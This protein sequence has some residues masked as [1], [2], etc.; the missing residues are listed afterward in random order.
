MR[1]LEHPSRAPA[2]RT[3]AVTAVALTMAFVGVWVAQ[4][5]PAAAHHTSVTTTVYTWEPGEGDPYNGINVFLS[6]P[7]HSNSGSKGE[8]ANGYEENINGRYHNTQGGGGGY[9]WEEPSTSSGRSLIGRGYRVQIGPNPRDDGIGWG[10]GQNGWLSREFGASVHITTHSN[11]TTGCPGSANHW[12]V[13]YSDRNGHNA[14]LAN[15]MHYTYS[16]QDKHPG[17]GYYVKH[18][19]QSGPGQLF[20]A[21]DVDAPH[22]AYIELAFHDTSAGQDYMY[23]GA[24]GAKMAWR[25]GW[26]VDVHLG[27][28]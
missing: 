9:Y 4:P 5:E 22:T 16:Y 1:C 10:S 14:G 12:E 21:G 26:A 13:F 17:S 18:E 20:E 24:L 2:W 15:E 3:W 11:G 28:P 6:A 25:M 19:S 8:C 7:R 23:S 27:Y